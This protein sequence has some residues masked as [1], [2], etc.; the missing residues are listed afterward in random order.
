MYTPI[1]YAIVAL[2]LIYLVYDSYRDGGL[3][4]MFKFVIV[5][6]FLFFAIRE[7]IVQPFM[8]DGPSMSPT[9]ET[10]HYLL[11]DKLSLNFK[12]L[13]RYD[14]VIFDIPDKESQYHTCLIPNPLKDTCLLT[15][16]RYLIKR[17][18]GLP[19]ERIAV[20]NA[21]TTI[22]NA[23]NP[24]GFIVD[25][26]FVKHPSTIYDEKVLAD[27]EYYVMGDNRA[28]SSDSR[29]FGAVTLD[30]IVGRPLMRL[31]PLKLADIYPGSLETLQKESQ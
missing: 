14:I 19:G 31:W 7:Y 20:I 13:T 23:D 10:G 11:V 16:K 22:Y 17:V 29:Y 26:N 25:E 2:T 8:V 15:S 27:N 28:N 9:F 12:T 6:G 5:F 18:I 4:E 24:N 3:K 21:V 1:W 30:K